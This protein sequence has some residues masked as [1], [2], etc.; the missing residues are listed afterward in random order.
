MSD[1]NDFITAQRVDKAIE[2][3]VTTQLN[4]QRPVAKYAVVKSIDN[5][6]RSAEVVY[7]GE[8]DP[9]RIPFGLVGPNEVGQEV[10]IEG[11][12]G[13]RY[14]TGI[15]G[16]TRVEAVASE[17]SETAANAGNLAEG[18][19]NGVESINDTLDTIDGRPLWD[20]PD[21]NGDSSIPLLTATDDI[22]MI[23]SSPRWVFIRARR[24]F[25][26][27]ALM[28]AAKTSGTVTNLFFDIYRMNVNGGVDLI[29]SSPN[30][31]GSLTSV[32]SW[33]KIIF[34][35]LVIQYNEVI[36]I[37]FRMAG[38]GNIQFIGKVEKVIVNGIFHPRYRGGLRT[39]NDVP[40]HLTM[41][42]V[43]SLCMEA[44]LYAQLGANAS[45]EVLP[46]T[47]SDNFSGNLSKW[48]L[49]SSNSNNLKIDGDGMLAYNGTKDGRQLAMHLIPLNTNKFNVAAWCGAINGRPNYMLLG[50]DSTLTNFL[51]LAIRGERVGFWLSNN[52][53]DGMNNSP[54]KAE[55]SGDFRAETVRTVTY[56]GAG[57]WKFFNSSSTILGTELMT[58]TDTNNEVPIGPGRRFIGLGIYRDNY[59]NGARW[60]NFVAKDVEDNYA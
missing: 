18:A 22:T 50:C 41:S 26:A 40:Q 52:G 51:Y 57:T 33:Q 14:I 35:Q 27:A 31:L 58:W 13:D 2:K 53:T 19:S 16:T 39:T 23:Q 55:I 20:G 54:L 44:V 29:Y 15:R 5:N 4:K 17:A 1:L 60:D 28:Y 38:S 6:T 12:P 48:Y 25:A 8:S 11:T 42:Q 34:P 37:Q 30:V 32:Y 45:T 21:S 59:V 9:V 10:R 49:K 7:I 47:I 3:K 24:A 46:R 56:D 36:A 43:D